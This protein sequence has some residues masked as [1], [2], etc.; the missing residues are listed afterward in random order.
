MSR[1]PRPRYGQWLREQRQA[2]GWAAPDLVRRLRAAAAAAGDRLPGNETLLVMVYRW[3]DDRGGISERYRLHYC[4]VFGVPVCEFGKSPIPQIQPREVWADETTLML[5][6]A[7]LMLLSAS[8]GY[9]RNGGSAGALPEGLDSR[10]ASGL[11]ARMRAAQRE[12][13]GSIQLLTWKVRADQ[14][15]LFEGDEDK[16]RRF[17]AERIADEP[18]LTLESPGGYSYLLPGRPAD[19][20][21]GAGWDEGA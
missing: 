18:D 5:A 6:E 10:K 7:G 14:E 3:E 4:R 16:A 17:L 12:L 19:A 21:G 9:L 13:T 1:A 2:R 8:V 20:S 11:A 15:L